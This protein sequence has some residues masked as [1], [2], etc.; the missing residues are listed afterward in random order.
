MQNKS[1][2]KQFAFLKYINSKTN[3]YTIAFIF[4]IIFTVVI[5]FAFVKE[6]IMLE[7]NSL[8]NTLVILFGFSL[9]L[10]ICMFCIQRPFVW[11]PTLISKNNLKIDLENK[12]ISIKNYPVVLWNKSEKKYMTAK[13]TLG[14]PLDKIDSIRKYK[15]YFV[16]TIGCL[17]EFLVPVNEQT[18][19]ILT[20]YNKLFENE[21]NKNIEITELDNPDSNFLINAKIIDTQ[22]QFDGLF[23][24]RFFI[25]EAENDIIINDKNYGTVFVLLNRLAYSSL[26][27]NRKDIQVSILHD[28]YEPSKPIDIKSSEPIFIGNLKFL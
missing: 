19:N 20:E 12:I 26:I 27:G 9:C 15:K 18:Q 4:C 8:Y 13:H 21:I 25:A 10:D 5:I 14:I 7:E 23:Y 28:E 1:S 17:F 22:D 24:R 11:I 16:I 2:A 6:V 3:K